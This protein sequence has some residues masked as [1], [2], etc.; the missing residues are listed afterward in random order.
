MKTT[1]EI[2]DSLFRAAKKHCAERGIPLRELFESGLRQA[3]TQ[4]RQAG[5]F[6][7][8]PFGFQG[9]GQLVHDWS[10]IREMIYEGRGGIPE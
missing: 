1:V 8:K 4:P 6:R 7:L 5:R 9:E 2:P 3:L 10:R